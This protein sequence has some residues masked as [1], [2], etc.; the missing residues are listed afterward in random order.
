MKDKNVEEDDEELGKL[1]EQRKGLDDE[2]KDTEYINDELRDGEEMTLSRAIENCIALLRFLQLL[3]ENHNPD[4]QNILNV[5]TNIENRPKPKTVNIV[6]LLALNFEQ[7]QK[8]INS[9][10]IGMSQ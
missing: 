3:C 6:Q 2:I 7:L 9:V 10:T 4:M 1:V 8:I 5:Q